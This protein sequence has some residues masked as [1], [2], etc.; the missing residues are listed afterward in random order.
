MKFSKNTVFTLLYFV[1][2]CPIVIFLLNN[3]NLPYIIILSYVLITIAFVLI[4]IKLNSNAIEQFY[5][6]ERQMLWHP[7]DVKRLLSYGLKTLVFIRL[8][9]AFMRKPIR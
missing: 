1:I 9:I 4:M 2:T 7:D 6:N 3:I 8:M 5:S